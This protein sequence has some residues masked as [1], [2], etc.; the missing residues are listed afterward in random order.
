MNLI[1]IIVLLTYDECVRCIQTILFVCL[2]EG[3]LKN[4][5]DP[6]NLTATRTVESGLPRELNALH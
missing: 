1:A 4:D 6:S 2:I 5:S 3:T